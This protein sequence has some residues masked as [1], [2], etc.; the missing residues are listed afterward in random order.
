MVDESARAV[1]TVVSPAILVPNACRGAMSAWRY[2]TS[3]A[4]LEPRRL[5]ALTFEIAACRSFVRR[6][7]A[8]AALA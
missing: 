6:V 3:D 8:A 4:A 7:M 5:V 1:A 2:A